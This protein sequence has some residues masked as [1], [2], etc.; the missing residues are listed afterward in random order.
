MDVYLSA[1]AEQ[2]GYTMRDPEAVQLCTELFMDVLRELVRISMTVASESD[3]K[4]TLLYRH[5]KCAVLILFPGKMSSLAVLNRRNEVF[6][7]DWM[8]NRIRSCLP[9]SFRVSREYVLSAGAYMEYFLA[10]VMDISKP[11]LTPD[12]IR[13]GVRQD[14]E[15][16]RLVT[17][18]G[19]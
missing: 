7:L 11:S 8:E 14:A 6:P 1:I 18:A 9:V 3:K 10:E 2:Q 17:F 19:I 4:R 12:S 15:L 5:G 16:N 13:G